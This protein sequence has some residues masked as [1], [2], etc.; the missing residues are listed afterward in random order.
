MTYVFC[1]GMERSGTHSVA[2]ILDSAARVC[3]HVAHEEPPELCREAMLAA[4]GENSHSADWEHKLARLRQLGGICELVCECNHRFAFF[5]SYLWQALAPDVRFVFL[6]RHPVGYV[7]SKV[8]TFAHWPEVYD[9]LPAFY[10]KELDARVPPAKCEFNQYRIKPPDFDRELWEL[11]L[12]EYLETI[13]LAR[14]QLAAVPRQ[15]VMVL[16]T[17][18]LTESADLLFRFVNPHW[19]KADGR[20]RQAIAVKHDTSTSRG[21]DA[22]AE[23]ARAVVMP[24]AGEIIARA[25][26]A[27]TGPLPE[28]ADPA[29]AL[30]QALS[31]E[32]LPG[33]FFAGTSGGR[34]AA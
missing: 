2:R 24:Y 11:H 30:E 5:A 12:W 7:L 17:D 32:L 13:R 1:V 21:L 25:A 29:A 19:F 16:N 15:Q 28:G 3:R 22:V 31:P 27:L 23:Y 4:A 34:Q 10:R 9:R 18:R 6:V 8:N 26:E 20:S 33:V 14:A